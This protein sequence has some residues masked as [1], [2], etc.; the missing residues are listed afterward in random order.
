MRKPRAGSSPHSVA[1]C[2][3]PH[4]VRPKRPRRQAGPASMVGIAS[5]ALA[6]M[7]VLRWNAQ[8][9][10]RVERTQRS[11]LLLAAPGQ[12]E[13]SAPRGRPAV[14]VCN[15]ALGAGVV[16]G[17]GWEDPSEALGAAH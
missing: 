10:R 5:D 11:A 1:P 17:A 6:S 7:L 13:P 4:R 12:P 14:Q 8:A 3:S 9:T 16:F 2:T 15:A